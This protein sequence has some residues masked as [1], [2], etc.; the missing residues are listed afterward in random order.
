MA[1]NVL[2]YSTWS[3]FL[4]KKKKKIEGKATKTEILQYTKKSNVFLCI[5]LVNLKLLLALREGSF[6]T[7]ISVI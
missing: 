7:D 2:A 5:Q 1:E 6:S 3:R 4:Q